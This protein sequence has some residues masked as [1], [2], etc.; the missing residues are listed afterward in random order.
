MITFHFCCDCVGASCGVRAARTFLRISAA[1]PIRQS[2][3]FSTPGTGYAASNGGQSFSVGLHITQRMRPGENI[4]IRKRL[5][6]IDYELFARF[7][8]GFSARADKKL[9]TPKRSLSVSNETFRNHKSRLS[10]AIEGSE[11]GY[12]TLAVSRGDMSSSTKQIFH[13]SGST[14]NV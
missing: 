12:D 10:R 4:K 14:R 5:K 1:G 9:T 3:I 6:T 11:T 8:T 7:E 13:F 2:R